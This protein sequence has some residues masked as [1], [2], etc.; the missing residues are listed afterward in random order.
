MKIWKMTLREASGSVRILDL[1][2]GS[3]SVGCDEAADVCVRSPG[4]APR[5]LNLRLGSGRAEVDLLAGAPAARLNGSV[6]EG[7]RV[8]VGSVR[9]EL[10]EACLEISPLAPEE[11]D[12]TLIIRHTQVVGPDGPIREPLDPAEQTLRIRLPE[13]SGEI[14][15]ET[16]EFEILEGFEAARTGDNAPDEVNDGNVRTAVLNMSLASVEPGC[17]ASAQSGYR[18]DAEIARGGIGRIFDAHDS[19]L[20]RRVAVKVSVATGATGDEQFRMEAEVLAQLAHPNI[21][22]VHA[23]G[24]T[25]TG[26]PFYAM[27]L[28]EGKTLK[29]ILREL[30]AR[31]PSTR[32]LYT[33][34]RLLNVLRKVCDAVGFA[35][36]EGYL[37]RDLKP[38]NV[39]VG[40]FGEVL[41]MDWGLARRVPGRGE[42]GGIPEA[43]AAVKYI[44]GSPQYMSPEQ[45]AGLAL[46]ERSDIYALGAILYSILTLRA[47]VEG[48]SVR[49][50]LEKVKRCEVGDITTRRVAPVMKGAPVLES[51]PVPE[52]LRAIT[53][54]A[55]ACRRE[56]RY[57]VVAEFVADIE[58]YQN[59]FATSAENAGLGRQLVLLV[60]RHRAASALLFVL[61]LGGIWFTARLAR[62]ERRARFHARE[63]LENAR[64]AERSAEEARQSAR[65]AKANQQRAEM[66]KEKERHTAALA[67]I[68]LAEAAENDD[69]GE[70][71]QFALRKVPEDLRGQEWQYLS[72]RADS[73]DLTIEAK[74]KHAWTAWAAHPLKPGV[75]LALQ[76]DGWIRCVDLSTGQQEDLI[77]VGLPA[78]GFENSLAVSEDA[79]RVAVVF[80]DTTLNVAGSHL[81]AVVYDVSTGGVLF[82]RAKSEKAVT[83]VQL[84]KNGSLL[85]WS[86]FSDNS[87]IEVLD[88][89]SGQLLWSRVMEGGDASFLARFDAASNVRVYSRTD[90]IFNLAA[91]SGALLDAPRQ[92]EIFRKGSLKDGQ[93]AL[94]NSG[95]FIAFTQG[96]VCTFSNDGGT[97]I[98]T[99]KL[100]DNNSRISSLQNGSILAI[101]S[102]K[103]D[104]GRVLE[105]WKA[106][107]ASRKRTV[108]VP[109]GSGGGRGR[110]EWAL[111]THPASDHVVVIRGNQ[112]KVWN[113]LRGPAL[114]EEADWASPVSFLGPTSSLLTLSAAKDPDRR[115]DQY[116]VRLLDLKNLHDP[117][118]HEA[119]GVYVARDLSVSQDGSRI[120]V[121]GHFKM[122]HPRSNQSVP[123]RGVGFLDLA[124]CF[125]QGLVVWV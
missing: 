37:H 47:P 68:A 96:S 92:A 86:L 102:T 95:R 64:K 57:A 34:E 23:S 41:V 49:E 50:V 117:A 97:N 101:L 14:G 77:E 89:D 48:A 20:R 10:G 121:T 54:K 91:Q 58:S 73:S 93:L 15:A 27:K 115:P 32:E 43:L 26:R 18:L 81:K 120:A 35:H 36:A 45:A 6:L 51:G 4:V 29:A 112:M 74:G 124:G 46:D 90:G 24:T 13:K 22:P 87:R 62:S 104:G 100:N 114:P 65:V 16:V 123:P 110:N 61:M 78:P 55:M 59:G 119:L 83:S 116:N 88:V 122:Y 25:D 76:M 69:N 60:K 21:V 80:K 33:R 1:N 79:K 63:A 72:K 2:E 40:A 38:E 98:K 106:S 70:E 42:V 109:M 85:L 108:P 19:G 105:F 107:D 66:E 8:C 31:E 111:F 94:A 52:P 56:M 82:E 99:I 75:M 118:K 7:R 11:S 113:P 5:H 39:M 67:Q 103:S 53:L 44:E 3:F 84:N 12:S 17:N 28:V 9:L 125:W 71:M 30:A